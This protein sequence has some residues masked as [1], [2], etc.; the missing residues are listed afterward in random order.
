MLSLMLTRWLLGYARFTVHGGSPE[1]F[2]NQCARSGIVLWDIRSG[3]NS[4]A[5]VAA[6]RYR[7][8]RVCA[9]KSGSRLKVRERHGFPFATA[10]I[11]RHRGIL[12]GAV[13]AALIFYVLSLH[14]WCIEVKGNTTIP[15]QEIRAALAEM[16]ITNG[17]RKK[18]VD[19]QMVQQ[20]LMIKFPEIGWLS[21]NTLGCN[22]EV[23][24]QEKTEKPPIAQKD[25]SVCNLKASASGQIVLLEVYTG[26]AQVKQ[27]DAVVAGQLLVSGVVEDIYG[28]TTLRRAAG[29]IIAETSRTLTVE[30]D[31]KRNVVEE[32]G[33]VV[34]RRSFHLF[35]ACIPLSFVGKPQGDYRPEGQLTQI[36]L[37]NSVLPI[38][39]YEENWIQQAT[40]P[41]TLNKEQAI[42]EAEQR[43]LQQEKELKNVEII[44]QTASDKI[45]GSKLIYT[46]NVKCRE[47]IAQE[48]EII[49]K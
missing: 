20:A 5:C 18:K 19:P 34:T 10:G 33:K 4:G 21:V 45:V 36:K 14:V 41:V 16:G 37:M 12:V 8:L 32:T 11:R 49:I 6:R 44:S 1:R 43:L 39:V 7:S 25:Y 3:E 40:V 30:V 9:K 26:T 15:T 13:L 2:L 23:T 42:R 27:G 22:A 29:K 38:S 17:T 35:N 46:A 24:L 48:S 31:M 28:T 47:N